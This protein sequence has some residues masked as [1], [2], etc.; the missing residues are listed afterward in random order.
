MHRSTD[1]E[2]LNRV[3]NDESVKPWVSLG[4]KDHLDT[5]EL[6]KNPD[7]LFMANEY[8]GFVFINEGRGCYQLHTQFL[9]DGRGFKALEAA[10]ETAAYFFTKTDGVAIRTFIQDENVAARRLARW[11]K[12]EPVEHATLNGFSGTYYLLTIKQWVMEMM[13]CQ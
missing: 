9:P 8:G 12:F 4:F 5:T 2:F 6:L 7:N 10:K 1:A 13:L 11:M 3:I